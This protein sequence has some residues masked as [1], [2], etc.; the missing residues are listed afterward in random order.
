MILSKVIIAPDSFKGVLTS[1]EVTDIIADEVSAVFPDCGIVKMPIADGGEG[2]VDTIL[3]SIGGKTYEATVLSPDDR[4]ISAFY[5]IAS[6]TAAILEMAQS[7]GI[8]KQNGL[9]P[10]TATTYGFGQLILAALDRGAKEFM[11]GIGGSAS[12]DGGCGMAS[13]LGIRFLDESGKSF[14]PS[15]ET[16]EKIARIDVDGIDKRVAESKFTVMCDVDNP[17]YGVNGAAYVYSP[18]KGA[19]PEQVRILDDGLRH[20]G[21]ILE[22]KVYCLWNLY[23]R[24]GFM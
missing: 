23:L 20:Y 7:S 10:M 14:V 9:H 12:T 5:G 19:T 24:L 13:A 15:G 17:L 21:R 16:L 11:L 4:E 22:E 1:K 3:S 8:T 18:Q 6:N 2:S